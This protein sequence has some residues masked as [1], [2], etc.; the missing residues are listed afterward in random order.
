MRVTPGGLPFEVFPEVR[1]ALF[2]GLDATGCDPMDA[3]DADTIA[4][5]GKADIDSCREQ[6]RHNPGVAHRPMGFRGLTRWLGASGW[7]PEI[8]R[9]ILRAKLAVPTIRPSV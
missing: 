1:E 7:P 4:A 9:M 8:S 2:G 5:Q 6:I 3:Q